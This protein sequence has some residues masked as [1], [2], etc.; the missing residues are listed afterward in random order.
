MG[1][2]ITAQN[3][4]LQATSRTKVAHDFVPLLLRCLPKN[5]APFLQKSLNFCGFFYAL[6]QHSYYFFDSFS[7]RF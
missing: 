5:Y 3:F 4:H 2:P 1:R 7:D 6:K